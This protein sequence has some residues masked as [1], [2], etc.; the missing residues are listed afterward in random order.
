M[1]WRIV[2]QPNGKYARFSEVV[3][4]F[5]HYGMTRDEAFD[6]C[7]DEAG[8]SVANLKLA[9]ADKWHERFEED[10]KTIETIHGKP[11]A[12]A[13]RSMMRIQPPKDTP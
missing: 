12:D 11:E 5:T 4:N 1:A 9:N 8:R 6:L 3:D 7:L 10:M 13:V 2:L